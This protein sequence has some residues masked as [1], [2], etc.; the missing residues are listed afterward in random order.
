[1]KSKQEKYLA[2]EAMKR[3]MIDFM[4]SGHIPLARNAEKRLTALEAMTVEEFATK[5][6]DDDNSDIA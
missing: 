1:M 6:P 3:N 2:Q 4:A 5:Y